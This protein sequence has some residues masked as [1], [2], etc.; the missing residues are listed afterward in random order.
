MFN[1][2]IFFPSLMILF[3]IIALVLISQ[4]PEPRYQDAPVG[5]DFFPSV[6]AVLQI[7][8]CSV[9]IIQYKRSDK[10]TKEKPLIS[11]HAIFGFTLLIGYATL[12]TFV[13]YLLA[14]LIGFTYYLMYHRIKKPSYYIIAWIFV[15]AI[16][17]LFSEVFIISLPE[18]LLFY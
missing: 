18:G 13:G 1:R 16:Y 11:S 6:I 3:S 9:L 5:A 12:I 8:I 4:F 7:I 17:F 2:N 15:F 14:S 10:A